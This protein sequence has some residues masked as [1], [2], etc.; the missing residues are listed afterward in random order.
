MR[1]NKTIQGEIDMWL[2]DFAVCVRGR[3][4][5]RARGL[6]ARDTHGFGTVERSMDSRVKLERA[7]W[8]RVWPRTSGFCFLRTGLRMVV[9]G[10][11][12]HVVVMA[13][14]KA[15]NDPSPVRPVYDRRGRATVVLRR[16]GAAGGWVAQ[17]THFSFDPQ[18]LPKRAG[19]A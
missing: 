5:S 18:S 14:W 12:G 4:F 16:T 10:D 19:S 17:H 2:D 15:C 9:S 11:G 13:R 3:D 7:Q 1:K 6:F 8:A